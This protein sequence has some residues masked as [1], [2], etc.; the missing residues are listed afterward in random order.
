MF[1]GVRAS[2]GQICLLEHPPQSGKNVPFNTLFPAAKW[3]TSHL[4]IQNG[5]TE[6]FPYQEQMVGVSLS[7]APSKG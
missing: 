3:P 2:L 7:Q 6:H 1:V 5:G 4:T